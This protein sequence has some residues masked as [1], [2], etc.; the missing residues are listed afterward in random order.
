LKGNEMLEYKVKI[1]PELVLLIEAL[2]WDLETFKD[3]IYRGMIEKA[4]EQFG[5]GDEITH[6]DIERW[7]TMEKI[8]NEKIHRNI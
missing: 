2:G 8:K 6:H 4:T 3:L 1:E 5:C 7:I